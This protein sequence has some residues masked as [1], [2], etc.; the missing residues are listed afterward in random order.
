MAVTVESFYSFFIKMHD[1]ATC[2]RADS[3]V[4][5]NSAVFLSKLKWLAS[6]GQ[7]F[8]FF[9]VVFFFVHSSSAALTCC[10][11]AKGQINPS[12]QEVQ[13]FALTC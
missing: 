6:F 11:A 4:L 3:Q 10:E 9:V 13:L 5:F 7:P 12:V 2:C 8:V 1:N